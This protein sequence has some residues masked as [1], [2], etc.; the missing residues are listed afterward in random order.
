MRFLKHTFSILLFSFLI[1]INFLCR[2]KHAVKE[3]EI[4]NAPAKMDERVNENI[5]DI[6]QYA[7]ANK[8]KINDSIKL[9]LTPVVQS[10]YDEKKY[11]NVWS[12]DEHWQAVADSLYDFIGHAELY[13]LFPNDY[14][15]KDLLQI[16]RRLSRDT[17]AKTDAIL[18]SDADLMLTDAFMRILQHLKQGRLLPDSVSVPKSNS[19]TK[20][21]FTNNLSNALKSN[22]VALILNSVEPKH[23][24]YVELKEKLPEF[25]D[26]MDKTI[27]TYLFYPNKD[28]SAFIKDLQRRLQQSGFM[29]STNKSIDSAELSGV[30]K[31]VQQKKHIKQD[32]KISTALINSLNSND[33]EKFKRIAINLDRYKL[34]PDSL[35]EK[36][37]WVNLPA[38][39]LKV[40]EDDTVAIWSKVIVGKP[41]THTPVL[42]S[43]ISD[44]VTYPQWTIPNSIIKKDILPALKS[45][46]GYLSRKGFTLFDLKGEP[47]NPYS[48][49][50]AK[51]TK[52]IPYKIR[53]GSGDDNALGI[54]KFNFNNRYNVYLHDTNQRYLFK[55]TTRALSH[56][57]VRVQKWEEL[58]FFIARNDSSNAKED[59]S[60]RYNSDSIKTWLANKVRKRIAVNTKLP[61]FIRYFTCEAKNNK[62]VFYDDIYGDDK[63]LRGKY[64]AGKYAE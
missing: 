11:G 42:N 13:G 43:Y 61:L 28:S 57:C 19:A 37:I 1:A 60:L 7:L 24:G 38:Y 46:P 16:K 26:S 29:D 64:F 59:D 55:N 48:I 8:G 5:S 2:G 15:L 9:F 6:L 35:P 54:L 58:A 53:Q 39:Y 47:V 30:I 31:K 32:G 17:I 62:I 22:S 25:L 33:Q 44:M 14:H 12:K 63:I 20:S 40:I 41:E 51:Y 34:L 50:W 4:V 45:D 36:Y 49:T 56:G 52:G 21:F 23:S 27:Y 18:W 3:K 10:F